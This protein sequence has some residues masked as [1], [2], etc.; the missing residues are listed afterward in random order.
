MF[1]FARDRARPKAAKL[2][3]RPPGQ[4]E[5]NQHEADKRIGAVIAYWPDSAFAQRP[6]RPGGNEQGPGKNDDPV[7]P[8]FNC[9]GT[10]CCAARPEGC[11]DPTGNPCDPDDLEGLVWLNDHA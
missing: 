3:S 9:G 2:N 4:R 1:V 6:R 5:T 7:D 8:G 10:L 11:G